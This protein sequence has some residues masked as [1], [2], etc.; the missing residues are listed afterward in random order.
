MR[1]WLE[2][3]T[4]EVQS[5]RGVEQRLAQRRE[6]IKA[7]A[8]E[9]AAEIVVPAFRKA[10]ETDDWRYE[11]AHETEWAVVRCGIYGPEEAP[12][13]PAAAFISAEFDAYQP[14][15]VLQRK[16]AG[17]GAAPHSQSLVLDD[18]DSAAVEAFIADAF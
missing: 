9:I 2:V 10:A 16:A 5:R 1:R 7:R 17:A 13:D 14:M 3:T 4:D 6:Q 12:R 11:E 15:V 8:E 18:L